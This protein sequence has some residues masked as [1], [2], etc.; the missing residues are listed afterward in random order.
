[1]SASIFLS[2][3]GLLGILRTASL[4]L[5]SKQLWMRRCNLLMLR[6]AEL[7]Y[8]SEQPATTDLA[9]SCSHLN[10]PAGAVVRQSVW[11]ICVN[12]WMVWPL[13]GLVART[14][15]NCAGQS[16]SQ[17]QLLPALSLALCLSSSTSSTQVTSSFSSPASLSKCAFRTYLHSKV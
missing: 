16:Q 17:R 7:P 10:D 14:Q 6:L 13:L 11:N 5:C 3:L 8:V 12:N 9:A 4:T 2:S 1:M 15:Q